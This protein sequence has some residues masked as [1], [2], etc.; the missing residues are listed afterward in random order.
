MNS[1]L[2]YKVKISI[3]LLIYLVPTIYSQ[4]QTVGLFLNTKDSF[5]GYTL[6]SNNEVTYL[7]D[8]CG[9]K[10]NEWSTDLKPGLGI[11]LLE[12]GNL[13]RTGRVDPPISFGGVGGAFELFDWDNN[14]IWRHEYD[15]DKGVPHHD[16]TPL[17]NGNFLALTWEFYSE[18]EGTEAGL[19]FIG[20][21]WS[22]RIVEIK[23]AGT[24]EAEIVWE[25]KAWDHL[26]QDMF[27]AAD[28]YGVVSEHTELIHVNFFNPGTHNGNLDLFHLNSIDYNSELDQIVVSCR[29]FSE[30]WVIDHSTTS[31]ESASHQGGKWGKG[32]DLLYRYGN[33]RAYDR[34]DQNDQVFRKQHD[35]KWI[36]NDAFNEVAFSVFSNGSSATG[37]IVYY[38]Q[39]TT[40]SSGQYEM[41]DTNV[42]GPEEIQWSF[43]RPGLYSPIMS[44]AQ[45]LE[46]G[47]VLICEAGDGRFL[48]VNS[49]GE[50][51][52]EYINPS[53][54]FGNPLA[55]GATVRNIDVFRATRYA[56][57]YPAFEGRS[58]EPTVP[59][60]INPWESDCELYLNTNTILGEN[61]SEISILGN[62]INDIL[63]IQSNTSYQLKFTT[64]NGQILKSKELTEGITNIDVTSV[65]SGVYIL[66]FVNKA[67]FSHVTKIIKI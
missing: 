65:Q 17:P 56:P 59:V 53:N 10:V 52:W 43:T 13:L 64:I 4:D 28:N 20:N 41:I 23:M 54:S 58:L 61:I 22:E 24:N 46:N 6:F 35:A 39:A 50:P 32:G 26:V 40:N 30:I 38:W 12:D 5:N 11:Y 51:V 34:G 18:E 25:W 37:S 2:I 29:N 67:G 63:T 15:F 27:P 19:N 48:E 42:F 44:G 60:E 16:I 1:N 55:Q 49:E 47:N 14:L 7:I 36:F 45:Y 31:E 57:N 3:L 62:P 33:P 66:N 9:F 8:N 21:I